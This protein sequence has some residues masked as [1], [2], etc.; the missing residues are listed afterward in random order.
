MFKNETRLATGKQKSEQRE[1]NQLDTAHAR[2]NE[3]P[4]QRARAQIELARL[5]STHSPHLSHIP[6]DRIDYHRDYHKNCCRKLNPGAYVENSFVFDEQRQNRDKQRENDRVECDEHKNAGKPERNRVRHCVEVS[7]R[8][9]A[10]VVSGQLIS[11]TERVQSEVASVGAFECVSDPVG[12]HKN[13][14]QTQS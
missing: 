14:Q 6:T 1:Q 11:R 13:Y 2:Q 9:K 8:A 10:V 4:T 12:R 3:R 5:F 7:P